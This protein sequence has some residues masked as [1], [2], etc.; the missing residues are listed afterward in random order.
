MGGRSD[1]RNATLAFSDLRGH[2]DQL[3]RIPTDERST[4]GET[5]ARLPPHN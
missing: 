2:L 3:R 1:Y 5:G 4:R